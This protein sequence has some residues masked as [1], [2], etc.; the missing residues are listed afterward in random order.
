MDKK[1]FIEVIYDVGPMKVVRV[2]CWRQIWNTFNN[3]SLW[4][5]DGPPQGRE[6]DQSVRQPQL[7]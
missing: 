5:W 6:A 7:D 4:V 3:E 1:D 2:G